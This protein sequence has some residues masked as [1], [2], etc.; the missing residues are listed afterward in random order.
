[1]ESNDPLEVSFRGNFEGEP[2][3]LEN[4]ELLTMNWH[5]GHNNSIVNG[6]PRI[7]FKEEEKCNVER[8]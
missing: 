2:T 5:H 8:C 3:G 6:V 7:G 4:P 1:M